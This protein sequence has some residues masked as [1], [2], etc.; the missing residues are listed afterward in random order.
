MIIVWEMNVYF[1]AFLQAPSGL[2]HATPGFA[3]SRQDFFVGG[4]LA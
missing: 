4:F 1:I 3:I 2:W